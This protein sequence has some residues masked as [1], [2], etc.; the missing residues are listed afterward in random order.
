MPRNHVTPWGMSCFIHLD[1]VLAVLTVGHCRLSAPPSP[2]ELSGDLR[3]F[4]REI[5]ADW[6]WR[7]RET[8]GLVLLSSLFL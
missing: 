6:E 2:A 4:H 1:G 8:T 7:E 5:A 3:V